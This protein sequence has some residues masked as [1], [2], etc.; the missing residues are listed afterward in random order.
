MF[1]SSVLHDMPPKGVSK[2]PTFRVC[3]LWGYPIHR[4]ISTAPQVPTGGTF[5]TTDALRQSNT[6]P[7][8]T[9]QWILSQIGKG[10]HPSEW[11]PVFSSLLQGKRSAYPSSP[12]VSTHNRSGDTY[13]AI[14]IKGT[15]YH[16]F[17]PSKTISSLRQALRVSS[18]TAANG[19]TILFIGVS[20]DMPKTS[21]GSSSKQGTF[22]GST[23]TP[24]RLGSPYSRILEA[25]AHACNQPCFNADHQVWS[26]GSFT[27]LSTLVPQIPTVGAN[28]VRDKGG[29]SSILDGTAPTVG[30][31]GKGSTL[32][33]VSKKAYAGKGTLLPDLIFFIGLSSHR[34]KQPLQE[35]IQT[36]I[37]VIAVVD[38][39]TSLSEDITSSI[40][41]LIP[42]NDRSIQS[43]A[44]LCSLMSRSI[45]TGYQRAQ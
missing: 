18:L 44:F 32:Y 42:A 34:L 28:F 10:H 31:Y 43:Y 24:K 16:L 29:T 38:S 21:A 30:T 19:G 17:N 37:P 13:G 4:Q 23:I 33:E 27:N 39:N 9:E 12:R 11:N 25:A 3:P 8:T 6:T 22:R 40:D 20:P 14:S 15:S 5:G 36:G 35:A 45:Q 2:V 1:S 26:S 41:Y 7:F